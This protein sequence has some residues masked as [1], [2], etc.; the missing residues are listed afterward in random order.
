[1]LLVTVM[2]T[3]P[4][5]PARPARFWLPLPS[6][7]A[8]YVLSTDHYPWSEVC[9]D[10]EVRPF[11]SAVL[12][13]RQAN[14]RGR[15]LWRAGELLGGFDHGSDLGLSAFM[16]AFPRATLQLSLVDP[17]VVSL[18]WQCRNAQPEALS[19]SWPEAQDGL[20]RSNFSGTLLGGE[21]GAAISYWQSGKPVAGTLPTGGQVFTVSAPQLMTTP[22][23]TAF[24]TQVMVL[25]SAQSRELPEVWRSCAG[26]LADQHPCLDPF[27]REVW[28]EKNTLRT[29]PGTDAAELRGALLAVF[30]MALRRVKVRIRSLPITELQASPL[31]EISGAG[32]LP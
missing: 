30:D 24:W 10:I 3:P 17:S 2:T 19:A 32:D 4:T 8:L 14:R 11:L 20:S 12:E 27:A 21:G 5:P 23:L 16:L 29:L 22:A 13:A 9:A 28:L 7:Q 26:V 15:L 1:M 31:W 18:A 25:A 6:R